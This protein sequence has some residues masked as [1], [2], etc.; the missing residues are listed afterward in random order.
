MSA[1]PA[2]LEPLLLTDANGGPQS[3]A[4]FQQRG[5]QA[6]AAETLFLDTHTGEWL[7]PRPVDLARFA[8]AGMK[9]GPWGSILDG[10]VASPAALARFAA[11]L[12]EQATAMKAS[13]LVVDGEQAMKGADPA[14][15]IQALAPFTGAKIFLTLGAAANGW[16][17]P[18]AYRQ[19][20]D[21]DWTIEQAA[22][23][24]PPGGPGPDGTSGDYRP[25]LDEAHAVRAGIP[26]DRC[27]MTLYVAGP[28]SMASLVAELERTHVG[29]AVTAFMAERGSPAEWDV[30]AG[31]LANA[32]P[33][34]PPT[35]LPE[36]PPQHPTPL[37]HK[38]A[39]IDELKAAVVAWRANKVGE[40][41]IRGTHVWKAGVELDPVWFA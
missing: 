13:L 14:P 25:D 20:V 11:K 10:N 19:F 5:F 24:Y 32:K 3:P 33:P 6:I 18:I 26:L 39:A 35:P 29:R 12:L 1:S 16:T 30:L 28:A 2:F 31:Y 37:E 38:Q 15:L 8:A 4:F 41:S 7:Q 9:V 21:A 27:R 34:V 40:P 17:H 23:W 36:L 22:Y